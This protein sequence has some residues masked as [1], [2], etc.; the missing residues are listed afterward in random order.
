VSDLRCLLVC[1]YTSAGGREAHLGV[2]PRDG[3]ERTFYCCCCCGEQEVLALAR[4]LHGHLRRQNG[5]PLEVVETTEAEAMSMAGMNDPVPPWPVRPFLWLRWY[6]WYPWHVGGLAGLVALML[7]VRTL[8]L[9]LPEW[10]SV[11][12][13]L[14]LLLELGTILSRPGKAGDAAQPATSEGGR[15]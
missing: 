1:C 13:V 4:D 11:L 10:V 14:G 6:I 7:A 15:P 12:F 9:G 8:D 2:V 5:P 3:E